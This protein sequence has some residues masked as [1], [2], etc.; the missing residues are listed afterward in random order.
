MV[1]SHQTTSAW[2]LQTA[3]ID[4]TAPNEKEADFYD[5]TTARYC[6]PMASTLALH[7]TASFLEWR[8]LVSGTQ[9]VSSS[10][11]AIMPGQLGVTKKNSRDKRIMIS[12]RRWGSHMSKGNMGYEGFEFRS[13]IRHHRPPWMVEVHIQNTFSSF[14]SLCCRLTIATSGNRR[15]T[16]SVDRQWCNA[17][18]VS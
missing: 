3:L 5:K 14:F 12:L 15:E 17:I 18:Q 1:S 8:S 9:L 2:A 6:S 4:R 16:N 13:W 11:Y 7:P 10:G